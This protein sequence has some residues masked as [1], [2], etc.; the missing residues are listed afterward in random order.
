MTVNYTG[1]VR[2][3]PVGSIISTAL[4]VALSCVYI[5]WRDVRVMDHS[6]SPL[7]RCCRRQRRSMEM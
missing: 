2:T 5:A 4:T 1:P 7:Q 6:F 3:R